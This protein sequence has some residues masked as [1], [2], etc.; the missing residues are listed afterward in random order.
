MVRDESVP[1]QSFRGRRSGP[2]RFLF[3]LT[4]GWMLIAYA[5]LV[6]ASGWAFSALRIH[7]DRQLTLEAERNRLRAVSAAMETGTLAM[8]NDGVGAAVAGA[9]EVDSAGG[10][11]VTS[12]AMVADTLRKMLTGGAYVR[13]LFIASP[14]RFASAGRD[15]QHEPH[16]Q[17]PEWLTALALPLQERTW[18]G[19]PIPDPDVPGV[20]VIPIA[21]RVQF[22]RNS[23]VW[24]GGLFDFRGFQTL[25]SQLGSNEIGIGLVSTDG[26]LLV[27]ITG[28][29]PMRIAV[30]DNVSAS[31]LFQRM[32]NGPDS[33]I[34]EGF[35]PA[36]GT[37]M[38]IAYDQVNDY[39]IMMITAQSLDSLLA[40]WRGRTN[41]T[42]AVTAASS[43]L[44]V[45][46]TALLGHYVRALSRRET[47]YRALF[48]NA[49]F[50]ALMLEGPRFVDA[51]DT[52]AR[53]FGLKDRN[54]AIGM[55]PWELSPP[56]Q[57]DGRRSEEAAQG[58]IAEALEQRGTT[59]EWLHLRHDTGETF[60]A[61]VDLTSVNVGKTT[62]ALAVVHDLTERKRAEQ[63][64]KESEHRYRAL[65]DALPE[66]VF[67][68]R[69]EE[70]LFVNDAAVKL[71][72]ARSAEELIGQPALLFADPQDR[73]HVA[74]RNRRVLEDGA[75]TE[76][77]ETRVRRVDGSFIWVEA[78]AVPISFGGAPA[79]QGVMR[80]VSARKLREEAESARTDRMQRQSA[81]L[82]RLANRQDAQW[83]DLASTVRAIC[84]TAADV[85]A[86]DR[87]G[88]WMLEE[89][90]RV[91]RCTHLYERACDR[92]SEGGTLPTSRFPRFLESL[93]SQRVIESQDLHSD[94]R[95]Q[96]FS[97]GQWLDPAA[98]AII[99]AAV[100]SSGDLT[101]IVSFSQLG[102]PRPWHMDE[103]T[104]AGGIG[105]QVAQALLDWERERV[106]ADLR[107]L[108]GELMRI[109][110]EERRRVGRDLHDSTGQTLAA[111]ELAL[112]RLTQST[113]SLP[114]EPRGLL[115]ECA[116]LATLCSA[117]IRTA[118]YLLHPPLLDELGLVSALRWLADGLRARG[119]ME[120]RLDLPES[121]P[122][123]RP[124]E[125]LT[126][127]RI[128]QEALTNAQRHSASPW[129]QMRLTRAPGSIDLE[130]EDGG[131][132]IAGH[133]AARGATDPPSLGV[134]LAGMRERM[135]Q[136]GGTFQVESTGAGTRIR[137]SI[138]VNSW[139]QARS[140]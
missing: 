118:S 39:P 61:E 91:L 84:A 96:E 50:S 104:F 89:G 113:G 35:A 58:R 136:I 16:P 42:L 97:A 98:V 95:L 33:G 110:D 64:L 45:L 130:V 86:V 53:M 19:K 22:S 80:D 41:T 36:F 48:N 128:A 52:V 51:N 40:P 38:V 126:L 73:E 15:G 83:A 18:V 90:G 26:T 13:S 9:N 57:P 37:R 10:L 120:V 69:G 47:H 87:I 131:R 7:T 6:L 28:T 76:P 124:E 115:A 32:K 82:M 107:T 129:V 122:R 3:P 135:R 25:H 27:R 60:P 137:A 70:L 59:F 79:L 43:A 31:P 49:A 12:D 4:L 139:P 102:A 75:T 78:E 34:V 63:N 108:A 1:A 117:E 72:G 121:I 67:V 20:T 127:F 55:T 81:A 77:R 100:R 114:P 30:G 111:L 105:D 66:A 125:E 92:H 140:A 71:V 93:R 8:L 119:G 134:G 44:L 109:Q 21:Q 116:R 68:H 56:T 54:E 85:L 101:G 99:A 46:M 138:V 133:E 88:V 24:A 123:L 132:G 65:V 112:S 94:P 74:E 5:T 17:P 106:L 29:I 62:L 14:T 103:V 11:S 23:T 2:A